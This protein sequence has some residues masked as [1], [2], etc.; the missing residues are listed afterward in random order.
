MGKCIG[1]TPPGSWVVKSER[2]GEQQSGGSDRRVSG[3]QVLHFAPIAPS[4]GHLVDMQGATMV[5][6]S[7]LSK[8]LISHS[9]SF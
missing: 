4:G 2:V 5:W 8:L 3:H 9:S 6:G 7:D 1:N